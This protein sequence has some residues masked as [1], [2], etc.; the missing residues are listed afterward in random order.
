MTIQ[1]I[2]KEQKL[3]DEQINAVMESMKTN[4]IFTSNEENIDIRY[5]KLKTD[6]ENTQ[7]Q[8]NEAQALI[9]ELKKNNQGNE[10]LTTKITEYESKIKQLS[11]QLASE[12]LNNAVKVALLSEKAVDIDYL[13]YKLKESGTLEL[14]DK[15]QIKD[16]NNKLADLKKLY[17][18][19]FESSATKKI[20]ENKLEK[21]KEGGEELTKE[22]FL[23]KSY[24]E[25]AEF[26]QNHPEEFNKLMNE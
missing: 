14:D 10:G 11:E 16:W 21:G 20:E 26:Y 2:L 1:D 13:T 7:K 6:N 4:K 25:R 9:A 8:Y 24:K 23:K 22:S 15:E 17:P 12:K 19:Q 3:T 18:T 5:N